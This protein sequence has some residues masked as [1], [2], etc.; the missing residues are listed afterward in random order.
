MLVLALAMLAPIAAAVNPPVSVSIDASE[1]R[2]TL[3]ILAKLKAGT[4]VTSADW[5]TLF[6]TRGYQRLKE[7]EAA[8]KRPFT[9]DDFKTFVTGAPLIA[10]YQSLADAL[11]RWM[12]ADITQISQRSFAY[13]PAGATIHATVY[14]LIKPRKN[15]FVYQLNTDPAIM[16]YLDPNVT[17]DQFSNTVSHELLHVGDSQNCP[18]PDVAAKEKNL[19]P[20]RKAMLEWLGAFGEGWAVLAAAGGPNLHPHWEDPPADRAVWDKAMAGYNGDFQTLEQFF[21][22]IANGT[23]TGDAIANQGYTYFG[24]VQGPW[25][26]VGYKMDVTIERILGRPVLIQA[27]CDKRIYL[28]TYNAAA[29]TSNRQGNPP[30]PLW[31]DNLRDF[32]NI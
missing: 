21:S 22:N 4:P 7:R 1:A 29:L 12:S 10:Q 15:S 28:A 6:A 14:P 23:L 8:F 5:D 30:L 31:P 16:L 20:R 24:A 32:L 19:D 2:A 26:T 27:L 13:L 18:P 9:D 3:A 11:Q 25:Y 17:T